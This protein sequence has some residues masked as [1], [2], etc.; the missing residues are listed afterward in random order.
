LFN[1]DITGTS[2]STVTGE[3]PERKYSEGVEDPLNPKKRKA[4]R[5]ERVIFFAMNMAERKN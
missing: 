4:Y 3:E 5:I 2:G 1:N